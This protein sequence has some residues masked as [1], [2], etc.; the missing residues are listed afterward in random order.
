M[1]IDIPVFSYLR[2]M[3]DFVATWCAFSQFEIL[4]INKKIIFIILVVILNL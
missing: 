4:A 3:N 2:I 1:L